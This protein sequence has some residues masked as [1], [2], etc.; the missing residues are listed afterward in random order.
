M[1]TSLFW[2]PFS[3]LRRA[4]ASRLSRI[5]HVDHDRNSIVFT[6]HFNEFLFHVLLNQVAAE[7]E[8]SR[9]EVGMKLEVI[10]PLNLS[11]ICVGTVFKVLRSHFLMIAVDGATSPNG[12]DLMC[13]HATSPYIFPAGFCKAAGLTLQPPHGYKKK[14]E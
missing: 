3:C 10:D 13:Y 1:T 11:T 4:A 9:F 6:G 7:F 2:R 14:F 12:S 8:N 5:F